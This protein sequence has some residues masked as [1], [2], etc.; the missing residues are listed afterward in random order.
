MSV[1]RSRVEVWTKAR[2]EAAR[3]SRSTQTVICSSCRRLLT[4]STKA[5]STSVSPTPTPTTAKTA[6]RLHAR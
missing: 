6:I 5:T 3:V 1:A 2:L 4:M